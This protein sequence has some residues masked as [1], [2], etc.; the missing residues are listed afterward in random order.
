[1]TQGDVLFGYRLRLVDL[2]AHTTVGQRGP[3]HRRAALDVLP[4]GGDGRAP[5]P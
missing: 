5:G 3:D 2:A 4:L 1:M